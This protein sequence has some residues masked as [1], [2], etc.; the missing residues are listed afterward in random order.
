MWMSL[1]T[2][3]VKIF[4]RPRTVCATAPSRHARGPD[5]VV[6]GRAEVVLWFGHGRLS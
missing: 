1:M 3:G 6:G 5:L 4:E 2:S